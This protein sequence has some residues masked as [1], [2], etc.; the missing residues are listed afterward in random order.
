MFNHLCNEFGLLPCGKQKMQKEKKV[1]ELEALGPVQSRQILLEPMMKLYDR[2]AVTEAECENAN[3][4]KKRIKIYHRSFL[5]R[6]IVRFGLKTFLEHFTRPLVEAV[7]GYHD[8]DST[9]S[10][11]IRASSSMA[12]GNYGDVDES[13]DD[14]LYPGNAL[15]PLD[16]DSSLDSERNATESRTETEEDA[17]ISARPETEVF[18]FEG[19]DSETE[20]TAESKTLHNSLL[21]DQLS[22]DEQTT[23]ADELPLDD[24][25]GHAANPRSPTIDI[26][27]ASLAVGEGEGEAHWRSRQLSDDSS[28]CGGAAMEYTK[29]YV[30]EVCE[31]SGE[32]AVWLAHR[33]GPMLS[34]RFLTRDLLRMLAL[35]YTGADNLATLPAVQQA[36]AAAAQQS[37]NAAPQMVLVGD[38]AAGKVLECLAL[39][40]ALYGDQFVV[41]QFLPHIGDL[42]SLCKRKLTLNLEG[43]LISC[44]VLFKHV[45]PFIS[46]AVLA[47]ILQDVILKTVIQPCVRLV[48]SSRLCLPSCGVARCVLAVRLLECIYTLAVRLT[49]V[50]QRLQLVNTLQRYFL[51]FSKPRLHQCAS[52][53]S[54]TARSDEKDGASR[55]REYDSADSC[56]PP[57]A[58]SPSAASKTSSSDDQRSK[59]LE[60]IK[61]VL[62]PSLA[63]L[64]F[65]TFANFFGEG[66]MEQTLKNYDL[67]QELCRQYKQEQASLGQPVPGPID[68][69]YILESQPDT[70][71]EVGSFGTV[72]GNRI[73]LKEPI[74]KSSSPGIAGSV[75]DAGLVQKRMDNSNRHLKG[76]WLAYWEHEIGRSGKD[77]RFNVKQIKLQSFG[78][79]TNSIRALHVLDNENSFFSASRDKTVKLWSLRSQ[80]DGTSTTSPQYTYSGHRKCVVSLAFV[81]RVRLA[82]SSDSVVHVWDPFVGRRL[83]Y[84]C[85]RLAPVNLVRALPAPSACLLAATMD[86]AVKLLDARTAMGLGDIKVSLN[87][88]GGVIRCMAVSQ[89]KHWVALGQ[90]SGQLTILD[91]RTGTVLAS[92]RGHEGEVLQL[93]AVDDQTIVS[94]SLDQAVSVWNAADG[95][96]ICHM[97][98]P[99]EPFHCLSVQGGELISGTTANRV[100]VHTAFDA[101]ATY[102]STRLRTDSLKG[103]LTVMEVLPLNRLILLGADTG[104]ISLIC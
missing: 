45:L 29:L 18:V 96:L 68:I 33:L 62:G 13:V 22:I 103:V 101:A 86:A 31:V 39:I 53:H 85:A 67:I 7:G 104:A 48:S 63:Y 91:L 44:L 89:G 69:P 88:T 30:R 60:E 15:S 80:G 52:R 93:A 66:F 27:P 3:R 32:S 38:E 34:A 5:L 72:I 12:G 11:G 102:T 58:S 6:L 65:T 19:E 25:Q 16:E 100:G 14:A 47:E 54:A 43:G 70:A 49:T 56:S 20:D 36:A 55:V 61:K 21:I 10:S 46:D 87:A 4:L 1:D 79:H 41:L 84:S 2:E 90:A 83:G 42:I 92:W 81:W 95:K 64:S 35:C 78:G 59:T 51:A 28:S 40:T 9:A 73:D 23:T 37:G 74:A 75:E 94:S 99:T 26:P 97:K 98:G 71:D 82:A 24:G 17:G 76:N 57:R 50:E 77:T 8:F